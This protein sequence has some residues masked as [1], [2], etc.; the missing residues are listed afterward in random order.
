[1]CKLLVEYYQ[2][3]DLRLIRCI[4]KNEHS[5]NDRFHSDVEKWINHQIEKLSSEKYA[6]CWEVWE[7]RKYLAGVKG[8]P[9]TT[10]LKKVVRQKVE[11]EWWPDYQSFGFSYDESARADL[12][13]RNN[14]EIKL[15]RILEAH[16]ITKNDCAV[17]VKG[18]GIRLPIMYEQG[19]KNNNCICCVKAGSPAYWARCR[20]FYP[21][22]FKRMCELS[23]R[24]GVR[25]AKLKG[26]RIFIDEIPID[27]EY[28]QIDRSKPIKC[29][30]GCG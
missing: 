8:A 26:R 10:E 19:F 13:A 23:R 30:I 22:E 29:G 2:H 4:V 11:R 21:T 3:A 12:F 14:P 27:Y 18:A 24:L 25:L 17:L 5:D 15:A 7:D 16:Q 1:M 28:G 9:C 20:Y 6:D